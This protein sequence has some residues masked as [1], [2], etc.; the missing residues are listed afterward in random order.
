MD[1]KETLISSFFFHLILLLAMAAIASYTAGL[2]GRIQNIVSV[3]L[4]RED[5]KD[6]AAAGTVSPEKPPAV[7]TP[8]SD[9]DASLPEQAEKNLLAESGKFQEPEKKSEAENPPA[10]GGG[11]ASL[12]DYHRFIM[13]HKQIFG[14]QA[15]VRVN[16]LLGEAFK[17]NKREFYGG[18]AVVYLKFGPDGRLN[19]VLVDSASP[20][21]KAFLEEVGWD[22]V[23]APAAY[24]LRST[25]VQV[26]FA[27]H[28][29]YLS[30]NINAL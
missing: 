22:A 14:Q 27:V 4:T 19:D 21:L 3:D 13:L 5:S 11:F 10:P 15:R 28:E 12:E 29:G 20:E 26:E 1:L 24:S 6:L 23:P 7:S 18:T 8:A 2:S 25:G 30:F 16:E 17:A 9:A